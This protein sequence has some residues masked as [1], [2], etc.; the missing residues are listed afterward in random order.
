MIA[1]CIGHSRPHDNG[2]VSTAGI[3]EHTWNTRIAGKLA[4]LLTARG[5]G[6]SVIDAYQ[7]AGYG[8]AM[9]WLAKKLTAL[10]A[11]VAVELHFNSA[12]AA[13]ASGHEWLHWHASNNGRLLAK[14]LELRMAKAF[15]TLPRRG[16]KGLYSKDDGAGFVRLTPCP[17]V[18]CEPMF[19]STES[20][21][22]LLRGHEDRY[23]QVLADGICDWIGGQA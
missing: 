22:Q 5:M 2:A 19:G 20:D 9:R 7:G 15:P 6:C 1:I 18:I 16:L 21:W 11:D 13:A 23:A 14:S 10:K 17:A 12:D 4:S 3:S 8:S